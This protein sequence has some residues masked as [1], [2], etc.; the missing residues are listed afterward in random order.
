MAR[1]NHVMGAS[2]LLFA[3]AAVHAEDTTHTFDSVAKVEHVMAATNI[4][5]VLTGDTVLSTVA[6]P[7][8]TDTVGDRCASHYETMLQNQGIY[9]LS[10]TITSTTNTLPNGQ[11]QTRISLTRCYLELKS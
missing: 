7:A 2:A 10:V 4:T 3:A 6:V 5:G 11:P 9:N 1:W 8:S